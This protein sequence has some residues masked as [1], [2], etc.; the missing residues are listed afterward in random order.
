MKENGSMDSGMDKEQIFGLMDL[1]I[2]E[3]GLRI[4]VKDMGNLSGQI[5]I[6]ITD[7]G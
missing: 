1:L 2:K 3:I 4:N 6:N 5:R 7:N